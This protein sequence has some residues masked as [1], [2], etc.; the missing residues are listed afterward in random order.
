MVCSAVLLAYDIT[1][2]SSFENVNRWKGEVE[3]LTR[4]GVDNLLFVL[5]GVKSDLDGERTVTKQEAQAFA[6]SMSVPYHE[7]SPLTGSGLNE[8]FD[9]ICRKLIERYR[10]TST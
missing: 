4:I 3:R 6:T 10:N 1:S 8:M 2:K 9:E 5:V 7:V